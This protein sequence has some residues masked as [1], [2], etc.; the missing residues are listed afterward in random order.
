LVLAVLIRFFCFC[1]L[2]ALRG[3]DFFDEVF[4]AAKCFTRYFLDS[5]FFLFL[6]KFVFFEIASF[7]FADIF[8][9]LPY[10]IYT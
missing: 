3:K 6:V 10:C 2:S 5:G 7:F 8:L 9:L 4:F 1:W